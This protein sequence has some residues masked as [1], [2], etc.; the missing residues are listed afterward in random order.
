[1]IFESASA[2]G[3]EGEYYSNARWYDPTLGRFITEDPARDGDNW[4]AYVSNNP[5]TFTDPTGLDPHGDA[6]RVRQGLQIPGSLPMEGPCYYRSLVGVAE[7]YARRTMTKEQIQSSI[8]AL[9]KGDNP[10]LGKDWIVQKSAEVIKDTLERLGV[11]TSKLAV[12]VARPGDKNYEAVKEN[13]TASLRNVG[14]I[15]DPDTA[16]HWQE[17]D[18]K[19]DFRWDPVSGVAGADRTNFPDNT[20]YVRIE[21]VPPSTTPTQPVPN[22]VPSNAQPASSAQTSRSASSDPSRNKDRE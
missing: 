18:E 12:A 15:S 21:T 20:R 7:T 3:G 13:A 17:G 6:R 9:S 2:S 4:F 10:A 5:L 19:G 22:S 1:M 11:D 16:G 8:A 14:T